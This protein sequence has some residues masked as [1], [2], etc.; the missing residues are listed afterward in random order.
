MYTDNQLYYSMSTVRKYILAVAAIVVMGGLVAPAQA[1]ELVYRPTN[2]AF[3]GS[4][5]N[6]QWLLSSAQAQKDQE[7]SSS[8]YQRDPLADFQSGLQRQILNQ[9]SRE[10]IYE[11]FQ[12]LDLSQEGSY[13]LGEY[14]VDIVP[15]L[16]GVSINVFNTSTGDETTVTIP[17][18]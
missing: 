9:L 14:S 7:T 3:G 8:S 16:D 17:N 5:L 10:L 11:R 12:D 18:Y 6:Y 4:Y 13:D 15:G 2:P 1:Q